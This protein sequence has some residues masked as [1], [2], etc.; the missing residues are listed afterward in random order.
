[1][2]LF[3]LVCEGLL[4]SRLASHFTRYI[5][6]TYSTYTNI[7]VHHHNQSA[8]L[9]RASDGCDVII[10]YLPRDSALR[11]RLLAICCAVVLLD[12]VAR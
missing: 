4:V 11:T 8:G 5:Y 12:L 10:E 3:V 2:A 7:Y 6:T 1:M 9:E